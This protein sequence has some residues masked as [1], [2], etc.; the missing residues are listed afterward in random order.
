[1]NDAELTNATWWAWLWGEVEHWAFLAVVV[2]LAIEFAALKLGAPHKEK[3]ENARELGIADAN[4]RAKEAELALAKF[5][6]PRLPTETQLSLLIERISPFAGTKFDVGHATEDR[7]QW[8]FLWRLE[9]ALTKA[10]WT[11]VD[12]LGGIVFR[13]N[14]WPG[15]HL[16]GAMAVI[17]VSIELSPNSQTLLM[18]AAESLVAALR[19]IEIEATIADFNNSSANTDAVHLLVGPKR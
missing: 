5:R 3:I 10:G 14:N 12:W 6:A 16:Y 1:M 17:N 8:D 13:K 18:P 15:N 9:P 19:E 4:R 2:A 7:E 11:H